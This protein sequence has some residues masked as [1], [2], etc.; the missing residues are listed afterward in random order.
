[1]EEWKHGR[2]EEWKNGRMEEC[3]VI[4][5]ES[6]FC[7]SNF[8]AAHSGSKKYLADGLFRWILNKRDKSLHLLALSGKWPCI[9]RKQVQYSGI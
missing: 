9:Q 2:M 8:P 6:Y 3:E 4:F 7:I 5:L 1:M